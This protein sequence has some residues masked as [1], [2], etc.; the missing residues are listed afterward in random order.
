[1]GNEYKMGAHA[2]MHQLITA[3]FRSPRMI[4]LKQPMLCHNETL[5]R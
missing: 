1:M 5:V 3:E 2:H 4:P